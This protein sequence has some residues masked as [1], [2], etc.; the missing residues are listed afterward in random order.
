MVGQYYNQPGH[1]MLSPLVTNM[2]IGDQ[3]A[4]NLLYLENACDF[5]I[6]LGLSIS[7]LSVT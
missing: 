7:N 1:E 5:S 4:K 3:S 2:I 6:P